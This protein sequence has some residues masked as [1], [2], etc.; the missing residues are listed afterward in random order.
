MNESS[1]FFLSFTH[2]WSF[3]SWFTIH[4]LW[5][6]RSLE[7]KANRQQRT[8]SMSLPINQLYALCLQSLYYLITRRS[9]GAI[10]SRGALWKCIREQRWIIINSIYLVYIMLTEM[11]CYHQLRWKSSDL[12][13]WFPSRTPCSSGTSCTLSRNMHENKTETLPSICAKLKKKLRLK[14]R[15]NILLYSYLNFI[16]P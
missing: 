4:S 2:D 3:R 12:F 16:T 7:K 9:L 11:G 6:L 8:Q 1:R 15:P 13:S 10:V 5:P 14:S